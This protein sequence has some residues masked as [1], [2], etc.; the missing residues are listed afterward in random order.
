MDESQQA[1][2]RDATGPGTSPI[3]KF[4]IASISNEAVVARAAK[5]GVSLGMSPSQVDTSLTKMK[6][7]DLQ[8]TII[9]LKRNEENK[10]W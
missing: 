6:D 2:D 5:L 3:P 4:S 7:A 10:I 1:Y 9:M 8:R